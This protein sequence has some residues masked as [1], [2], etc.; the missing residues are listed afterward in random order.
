MIP[1]G[2]TMRT[3]EL[4]GRTLSLILPAVPDAFL[5]DPD[6][7]QRHT[8]SQYMPYWAYLWPATWRQQFYNTPGTLAPRPSN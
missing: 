7:V 4:A 2:W 6:V 1:G 8:Q 3:W 5:D